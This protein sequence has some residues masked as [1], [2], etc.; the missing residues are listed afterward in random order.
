MSLSAMN[1]ADAD[2]TKIPLL[3][4]AEQYLAWRTRVADKC[5]ALTGHDIAEVSDKDC[6]A[7]LKL[8]HEEKD[9]SKRDNWDYYLATR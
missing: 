8:A 9:P 5:W 4:T 3:K 6:A 2:T 7:G 1:L